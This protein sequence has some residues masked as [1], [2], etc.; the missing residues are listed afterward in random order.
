MTE[1]GSSGSWRQAAGEQGL[2][3][4]Y[5]GRKL[6]EAQETTSSSLSPQNSENRPDIGRNS[7]LEI[8]LTILITSVTTWSGEA[9]CSRSWP[10]GQASVLSIDSTISIVT[11]ELFA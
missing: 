2:E 8:S 5:C 9:E 11:T 3:T 6:D 10:T 7:A 4:H 1:D